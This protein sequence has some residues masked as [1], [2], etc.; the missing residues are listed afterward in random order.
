MQFRISLVVCNLE[1]DSNDQADM[2]AHLLKSL[3]RPET[4]LVVVILVYSFIPTFG[5]LF[6]IALLS[7]FGPESAPANPR[8]LAE[9]FPF[10]V[11]VLSSFVFCI[12]GALQFLPSIRRYRPRAHRVNGSAVAVAGF[13][14]AATGLWMTIGYTFPTELQ[15][16]LLHWVRVVLSVAMMALIG[17]AVFAIRSRDVFQHGAAMLRAYAIGQGASTQAFLGIGWIITTGNEP[18]GILRDCVMVGAWVL[19]LA[20]AEVFIATW[21]RGKVALG[22]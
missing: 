8:A 6:R 7:G 22:H 4:T 19:N 3:S 5:G 18:L 1:Q 17:L 16:S 11:H 10:V 14:A 13:V 9:P 12:A 21:R 15:G 20:V 2:L